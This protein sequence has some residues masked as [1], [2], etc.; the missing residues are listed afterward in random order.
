LGVSVH[1][2]IVESG[3][4]IKFFANDPGSVFIGTVDKAPLGGD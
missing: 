2:A 3:S 1:F 4:Q